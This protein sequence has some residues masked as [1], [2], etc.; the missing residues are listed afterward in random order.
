MEQDPDNSEDLAA[1]AYR[2]HVLSLAGQ[3]R[4]GAARRLL[5][6]LDALPTPL[7]KAQLGAA[8]A[9]AGDQPRAEAAFAAALAAPARQPWLYD[10]GSAARDALAVA[11]LL[12]ESGLLP[13]R[14]AA[15]QAVLPGPELTPQSINT[16]EQAW[17]VVAAATLGRDGRPVRV[18]VNGAVQP[19]APRLA[20]ALE[21]PGLARNLGEAPV[22]AGV[23]VT[24][25]P[26]VPAA[27]GRGGMRV[28]RRFLDLA[29]Q[30][31]DLGRLRQNSV[32]VLLLEGRGETREAHRA[33]VQQGLPAG[34]EIVGRLAAG[35]AAGMP[36][37][38]TLTETAA[39]PALDDRLAAA[40][41]L[42]P[43]VAEF[44]IAVRL[45][46]VTAGQFELPGAQVEDMYRPQVFARQDTGRIAVLPA[47]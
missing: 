15:L 23:S 9:R 1:Q 6:E 32:F 34:W 41:D 13:D 12:K 31:L 24:G 25:I 27:A 35:E 20:V 30:P 39:T 17:A 11:A 3:P 43:E 42:T 38:G 21:A 33:L 44:R 40:I 28:S 10:Y 14:L 18:A 4:L 2:L 46:A 45:R 22:W 8:F 26:A 5:E 37:L 47:E 16:Q 29:G 19:P 36:W 7:A